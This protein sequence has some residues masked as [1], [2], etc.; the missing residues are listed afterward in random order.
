MVYRHT[1]RQ[2]RNF[3]NDLNHINCIHPLFGGGGGAEPFSVAHTLLELK[4]FLL[5]QP[6][7]ARIVYMSHHTHL[8]LD[9]NGEFC[10]MVMREQMLTL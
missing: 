7:S 1:C 9:C 3:V 4:A 10:H 6:P 2:K 8:G 5:L